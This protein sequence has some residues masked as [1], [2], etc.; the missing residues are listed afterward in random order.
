MSAL[1][2]VAA[3]W[4]HHPAVRTGDQ[5]TGAERFGELVVNG[6]GSLRF[7][8]WQTVVVVAWVTLNLAVV[9]LRWDA[10]P[11]ILLNLA[12]STQA[13]YAAPLIL[14]GGK[15]SDRRN[16]EV[17]LGSLRADEENRALVRLLCERAGVTPEEI[18]HAVATCHTLP[19]LLPSGESGGIDT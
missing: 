2:T 1:H 17:A 5:L 14:L 15:S 8:A 9:V 16:S 6:M 4:R 18:E 7:L 11:F 19:A 12:F 13:A 10:Y 3:L